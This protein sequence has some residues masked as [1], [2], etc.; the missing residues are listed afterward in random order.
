M[1]GDIQSISTVGSANGDGIPISSSNPVDDLSFIIQ[2]LNQE[3]GKNFG[4]NTKVHRKLLQKLIDKGFTSFQIQ[5][6]IVC[7]IKQWKNVD[8]MKSYIRPQTLFDISNFKRYLKEADIQ[9]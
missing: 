2:F 9:S 3:S 1:S 5:C 8:S 7:K 6:V 4:I